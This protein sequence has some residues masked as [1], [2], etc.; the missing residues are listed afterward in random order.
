MWKQP[1]SSAHGDRATDGH[2]GPECG[3]VATSAI[4]DE[5]D[6][7]EKREDNFER[8]YN[9]RFEEAGATQLVGHARCSL[10]GVELALG[11][12]H[13]GPVVR[14]R[15][16]RAAR[17]QVPGALDSAPGGTRTQ[18]R[19]RSCA[20]RAVGGAKAAEGDT[21]G[22]S[23]GARVRSHSSART[24]AFAQE[25]ELRRLKNLKKQA[26]MRRSHERLPLA[27]PRQSHPLQPPS[28]PPSLPPSAL[29]DRQEL[30]ER[31]RT[32]ARTA[33]SAVPISEEDLDG[34]FD[35]ENFDSRMAQVFD[36]RFYAEEDVG[37]GSDDGEAS[38]LGSGTRYERGLEFV[39]A[40]SGDP[41][42]RDRAQDSLS[43]YY[44][45]D[46]EDTL[47]D[48]LPTR[49]K[50]RKVSRVAA[51]RLAGALLLTPPPPPPLRRSSRRPSG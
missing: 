15:G 32:I 3:A 14:T 41:E 13:R 18:A 30:V 28:L 49:F 46:H 11:A 39:A 23:R 10:A 51:P 19:G 48:D 35:P 7:E 1:P 20:T 37:Y 34:D 42:L 17:P 43:E 44:S 27:D 2:D 50:Y 12:P 47:G 25:L 24:P 4:V 40:A 38:G 31:L 33:G 16:G 5:E 45:L 9:F 29:P 22:T 26:C 6:A 8:S 36:R 21:R